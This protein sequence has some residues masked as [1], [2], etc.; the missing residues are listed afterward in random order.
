M[1]LASV[2]FAWKNRGKG[3]VY[4]VNQEIEGIVVRCSKRTNRTS[5]SVEIYVQFRDRMFLL[6]DPDP[7]LKI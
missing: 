1:V 4:C 3:F 7:M 6:Q 5:S 2:F